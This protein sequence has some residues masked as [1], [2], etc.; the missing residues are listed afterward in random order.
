MYNRLQ[1]S[2]TSDDVDPSLIGHCVILLSS[3]TRRDQY[4]QQWYQNS[5]AIV[6]SLGKLTFFITMTANL[7]WPEITRK[8][9]SHQTADNRLN[10]VSWVFHLR[11][12]FLLNGFKKA[13]VFGQY[14]GSV[15]TIEYQKQRLSHL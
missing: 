15:Y 1:D 5:M 3:Y 7:N 10:I 6:Q 9:L 12:Q 2:L 13:Q 11:V 4:M 8:L 14:L